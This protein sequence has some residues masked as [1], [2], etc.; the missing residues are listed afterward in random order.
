METKQ[1]KRVLTQDR[2]GNIEIVYKRKRKHA[3]QQKRS[4]DSSSHGKV[5]W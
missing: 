4:Q 2:Y 1:K 3:T 5:L